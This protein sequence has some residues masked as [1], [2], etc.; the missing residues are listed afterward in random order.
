MKRLKKFEALRVK[1]WELW[2]EKLGEVV[3][4]WKVCEDFLGIWKTVE[5]VRVSTGRVIISCFLNCSACNIE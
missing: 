1:M 3:K 4:A 5:V 2:E